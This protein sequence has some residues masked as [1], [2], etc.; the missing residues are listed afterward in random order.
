MASRTGSL[1]GLMASIFCGVGL[2]V[3]I[4]GLLQM[5][6]IHSEELERLELDNLKGK[7]P[8]AALFESG[9]DILRSK[10]ARVQFEKFFIPGWTLLL[11]LV[12]SLVCYYMYGL[13]SKPEYLRDPIKGAGM[14]QAAFFLGFALVQFLFGKY[15]VGLARYDGSRLLR[16]G[17]SFLMLTSLISVLVAIASVAVQFGYPEYDLH[18]SHGLTAVAGLLAFEYVINMIMEIYRPRTKGGEVALLYESRLVGM[19]GQPGGIFATAAQT[20]DYQFG[21]SVSNTWFYQYLERAIVW[22]VLLWASVFFASSCFVVLEPYEEGLLERFGKPVK[23]GGQDVVGPGIHV[24]LPW[25]ID[26]IHRYPSKA[27]QR[28]LI[29]VVPDEELEAEKV[30]VWTR[31]HYKEEFNMLV[32]SRE[33]VDSEPSGETGEQAV[34]VNLLTVSIPIQYEISDLGSWA[35]NHANARD[36]LERLAYREIVR[37]LVS[38]DFDRI[39]SSGREAAARELRELIQGAAD[40]HKVGANILYV[41]LQDI[42]PPVTVAESWVKAQGALQERERLILDAEGTAA[43]IVPAAEAQSR[44]LVLE[45]EAEKLTKISAALA[46]S[47]Q[48][49]N[50]VS[51]YEA[52]PTTYLHRTYLNTLVAAIKPARKYIMATTNSQDVYW[53]NLEDNIQDEF[54]KVNFRDETGENMDATEQEE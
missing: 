28:L 1:A 17:G 31:A 34:P 44:Q 39:M 50:R 8:G 25:P 20:L 2:L 46:E 36:F 40:K 9:D 14:L 11:V 21:F 49:A 10:R 47:G 18:L 43:A 32:A 48:F 22:M 51:A 30:L 15:S 16:P 7:D 33:V 3:A 42:H 26:K 23:V 27:V 35:R 45:A 13:F 24:K 52:S 19:L 12:L 41:G 5:R 53:L 29:G 37:Y 38:V 6:H 54:L 4:V